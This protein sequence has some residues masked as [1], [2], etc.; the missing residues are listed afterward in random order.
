M[1]FDILKNLTKN[2]VDL[3]FVAPP[4][5]ATGDDILLDYL[6]FFIR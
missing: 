2:I 4:G 1:H 3:F 5:S 6:F